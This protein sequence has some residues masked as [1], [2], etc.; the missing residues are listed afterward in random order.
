MY[1][2]K[3]N[4]YLITRVAE[5]NCKILPTLESADT[6]IPHSTLWLLTDTTSVFYFFIYC[7][8]YSLL[9]YIQLQLIVT[10]TASY[11]AK[12]RGDCASKR[13]KLRSVEIGSVVKGEI[14]GESG[15]CDREIQEIYR[16]L[17]FIISLHS[18][19]LV[20]APRVCFLKGKSALMLIAS[21]IWQD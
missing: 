6:L 10:Y 4:K 5:A 3:Q 13:K 16:R 20:S 19:H 8:G 15:C 12:H 9:T 18:K 21:I 14:S 17:D 7:S 2:N 11:S 1:A